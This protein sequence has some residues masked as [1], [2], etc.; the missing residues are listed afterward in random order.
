MEGEFSLDEI[1]KG[2]ESQLEK[3][4][5][6]I[7]LVKREREEKA[8]EFDEKLDEMKVLDVDKE[9]LIKF[10]KSKE[11]FV[12]LP[13]KANEWYVVVPKFVPMNIGWLEHQT[14]SF[15]IFVITRYTSL[16]YDLPEELRSKIKLPTSPDFKV[17]DGFLFTGRDLQDVGYEKYKSFLSRREGNDRIRIQKGQE[18]ALIAKL[19]EDGCLPFTPM[20]VDEEDLRKLDKDFELRIFTDGLRSY[21]REAWNKF[22]EMGSL[23]IYW[24][25]AAGKSQF[26]IYILGTIKGKKL[27]VIPNLTLK[28][29]WEERIEKY[30]PEYKDEVTIVTYLAYEKVRKNKYSLVI[31]DEVH[32]LPANTYIKLS[33]LDTKYRIGLS[34]SPFREDGRENYI[35]ALTGYPIGT[36]WD[37][38]IKSEVVT[39]P[40]FKL[41]IVRNESS[42]KLK[43]L[44]ELLR[45]PLKTVIFCDSINLGKQI[46]KK[47]GIPFVYGESRDRLETVRRS[48]VCVVSRV[49]DEGISVGDLE[50]VIEVSFLFGSRRQESQ[51]FGRLMH[52]QK[53]EPEHIIIMSEEEFTI[54][55][56]RLNAIYE[57]GFRIE[58]VR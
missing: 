1:K 40:T 32:H 50:R 22:L 44:E 41:Y 11:K 43:K 10:L 46:S 38:L 55:Q 36:S 15:N 19:V 35:F 24:S 49:G 13:K 45:L 42:A 53:R 21:Q 33:T 27:V 4:D 29:Q 5:E 28:E 17:V 57:R 2:I 9:E 18:F 8:K 25:F 14:S 31:F 56:K 48:D 51:R 54:Y 7:S 20:P 3:L 58:I 26:G 47:F 6:Y 30:I 16:I 39:V 37:E 52:S 23:G 34:G 12:L